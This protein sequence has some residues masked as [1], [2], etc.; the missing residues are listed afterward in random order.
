MSGIMRRIDGTRLS[1]NI[2][3]RGR[4]GRFALVGTGLATAFAAAQI[5]TKPDDAQMARTIAQQQV[6][7]GQ[8]PVGKGLRDNKPMSV[9]DILVESERYGREMKKIFE[10]AETLRVNARRTRDIIR[11]TCV[12][13]RYGQI[14]QVWIIAEPRLET[15]KGLRDDDFHLRAQFTIIREGADRM[16]QLADE[17]ET[18]TGDSLENPA[19]GLIDEAGSPTGSITDPTLPANPV[20]DVARPP[21]SSPFR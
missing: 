17:I 8:S 18:C 15:I 9:D 6:S 13:D 1:T 21:D 14:R 19:L 20:L 10:H 11:M 5:A 2:V 16:R 12:D 4:L 3:W 7:S